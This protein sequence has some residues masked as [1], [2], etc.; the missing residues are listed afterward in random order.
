MIRTIGPESV[1]KDAV[2]SAEAEMSHSSTRTGGEEHVC[3]LRC[4][5]E[6]GD[7][8]GQKDG[9]NKRE[10]VAVRNAPEPQTPALFPSGPLFHQDSPHHPY[11][12][13]R[14]T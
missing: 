4:F 2:V 3:K 11:L 13:C 10:S 5:A 8:F 14:L 7:K 1:T 6:F 9:Q 12:C